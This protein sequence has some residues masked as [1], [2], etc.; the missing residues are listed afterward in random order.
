MK[1]FVLLLGC[2][3][4]GRYIYTHELHARKIPFAYQASEYFY[5]VSLQWIKPHITTRVM[6]ELGS[7]D[8]KRQLL[9]SCP[10][11]NSAFRPGQKPG[12][13]QIGAGDQPPGDGC[14]FSLFLR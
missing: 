6:L 7:D 12:V 8:G 14:K 9:G 10:K 13:W 3:Y 2:R 1:P 5:E 4:N 11:R